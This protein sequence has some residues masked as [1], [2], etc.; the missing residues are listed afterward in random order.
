MFKGFIISIVEFWMSRLFQQ[1]SRDWS[2][3]S[4]EATKC[5]QE[6]NTLN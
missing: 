2:Q 5:Y 1:A 6:I 3:N 4:I